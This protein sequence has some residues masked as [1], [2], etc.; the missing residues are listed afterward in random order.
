MNIQSNQANHVLSLQEAMKD[1][2]LSTNRIQAALQYAE[3]GFH[4]IPVHSIDQTTSQLK[5]TCGNSEC[6]HQG[7]HPATSNGLKDAT[8]DIIQITKWWTQNSSYNIGIVPGMSGFVV[9]D[10]DP[11]NNG[12]NSLDK[13]IEQYGEM[14]FDTAPRVRTGSGGH[15]YW[16]TDNGN[17]FTNARGLLPIGIDVRGS[18]GY[19]VAAPSVHMSGNTYQWENIDNLQ[20]LKH[21]SEPLNQI[22]LN[23]IKAIPVNPIKNNNLEFADILEGNRNNAL[24]SLAG[25]YFS[26][27]LNREKVLAL[28]LSDNKKRCSPALPEHEVM[29][30]VDSIERAHNKSQEPK[31]WGN[32][33]PIKKSSLLP[34][35]SFEVDKFLPNP[36]R[37][38]VKDCSYRTQTPPDLIA[39]AL[40]AGFSSLLGA[41]YRMHPKER[42]DWAEV[43]NLWNMIIAPPGSLKSN[44]LGEA[45]KPIK[46]LAAIARK[47]FEAVKKDFENAKI[48]YEMTKKSLEKAL[49][50]TFD[51]KVKVSDSTESQN[52]ETEIKNYERQLAELE[53]PNQKFE[54]RYITSDA[55]IEKLQELLENNTG[56]ILVE[57]DELIS[58]LMSFEMSGREADR[59]FYL[60]GWNGSGNY[61][62]DRIGRGSPYIPHLCLSLVGGTQPE[63]IQDYIYKNTSALANDGLIQRFQLMVYPDFT[64]REYVDEYPDIEAKNA[65]YNIA[66][67]I[68]NNNF[69]NDS[70]SKTSE[71]DEKLLL[72][73]SFE[74][75]AQA[76]FKGW[77]IDLE[78]QI[79]EEEEPILKEHWS[80]YRGLIPS[81]ALIFHVITIA[82]T[83][84][85]KNNPVTLDSLNMAINWQPYLESHA[86]RVYGM[87]LN[88]TEKATEALAKKIRQ[89]MFDN[90]F[91]AR[92]VYRKNIRGIGRNT[93]LAEAACEEL[94]KA[95]WVRAVQIPPAKGQKGTTAYYINP[96]I[97]KISKAA[98]NQV[99][100]VDSQLITTTLAIADHSP[101][102][103]HYVQNDEAV[104]EWQF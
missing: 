52:L 86:R 1:A 88:I 83:G 43:P 62:V 44:C 66:K 85:T 96:N 60:A 57:R 33:L 11:K 51:R 49:Q 29:K 16:F 79:E 55:T 81:L 92:D 13:L 2:S 87:G 64:K 82:L 71:F 6:N 32:P 17:I 12:D 74:K 22:I 9:I 10:V 58:L 56:G 35:S 23:L 70:R 20:A 39:T 94:E 38:F 73:F 97:Q 104:E 75:L 80:K 65:I 72:H 36:L 19:V 24:T 100:N 91:S 25:K 28:C 8:T 14:G 67:T 46:Y 98:S 18:S 77:L 63:K 103:K 42:D 90:C 40:V 61:Q 89:K 54:K 21:K 48:S 30:I 95:C 5:C 7:K 78:R 34:V 93:D 37:V 101:F 68:T 69:L 84:Q 99:A 102:E 59:G 50:A 41:E 76:R 3:A 15:H 31:E 26:E 47:N 45:L 4:L 53:I 27:N